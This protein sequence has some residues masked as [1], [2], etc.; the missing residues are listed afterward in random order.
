MVNHGNNPNSKL[1]YD[2]RNKIL[3]V[4]TIR[5]IEAGQ[6]IL[7]DYGDEYDFDEDVSHKTVYVW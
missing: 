6:Q 2:T 4:M 5:D 3:K 1:Y 7:A